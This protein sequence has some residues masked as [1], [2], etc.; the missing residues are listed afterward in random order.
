MAVVSAESSISLDS[1]QQKKLREAG[2]DF[3][4]GRGHVFS[5][6]CEEGMEAEVANGFRDILLQTGFVQKV[7]IIDCTAEE[8]WPEVSNRDEKKDAFIFLHPEYANHQSRER[9]ISILDK[10]ECTV[11]ITGSLTMAERD[12]V[13][14]RR[15]INSYLVLLDPD[16]LVAENRLPVEKLVDSL[17]FRVLIHQ[18]DSLDIYNFW[19]LVR[20]AARNN[21]PRLAYRAGSRT[22]KGA[23]IELEEALELCRGYSD[24]RTITEF[25]IS[26]AGFL[27]LRVGEVVIPEL[28][29]ISLGE[30]RLA[31]QDEKDNTLQ[32]IIPGLSVRLNREGPL[33]T[34][35]SFVVDFEVVASEIVRNS[36][37]YFKA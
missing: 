1:G 5:I 16:K 37:L 19:K 33:F 26:Q 24:P 36:R 28:L 6:T 21:I 31:L 23:P 18:N 8:S 2:V 20:E 27:H 29:G 3:A 34:I 15:S 12:Y 9:I 30:A 25:G 35:S 7:H 22:V 32:T 4:L 11:L 14:P 17:T 13:S 10:A